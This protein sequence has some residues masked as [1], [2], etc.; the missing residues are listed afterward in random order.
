MC[1]AIFRAALKTA[2]RRY[3][4]TVVTM[5]RLA[6]TECLASDLTRCATDIVKPQ[7]RLGGP[8]N[9][10]GN[11]TKTPGISLRRN[12]ERQTG[13]RCITYKSSKSYGSTPTG[14]TTAREGG[15]RFKSVSDAACVTGAAGRCESRCNDQTRPTITKAEHEPRE[16][17]FGVYGTGWTPLGSTAAQQE[18]D[19]KDVSVGVVREDSSNRLAS[20]AM[21]L[22]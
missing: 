19:V 11:G 6:M 3:R 8:Q 16:H 21:P 12:W 9:T 1:A 17:R 5:R 4:K 14:P 2:V 13:M 15:D 20:S 10:S 18:F 7:Y 22:A